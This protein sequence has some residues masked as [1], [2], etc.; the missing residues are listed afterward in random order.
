M[1]VKYHLSDLKPGEKAT[2]TA[3]FS[4]ADI[5]RRLQDIGLI[6]GTIVECIGRSPLGDPS[7]FL[8]R[9]AFIALRKK[10]AKNIEVS[11]IS[12]NSQK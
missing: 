11:L 9:G 7:A 12:Q 2:V 10:D 1:E 6:E 3:L 8:I 4:P 5:R